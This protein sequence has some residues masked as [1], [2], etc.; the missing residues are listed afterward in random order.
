MKIDLHCHTISTKNGEDKT[1]N[2][3]VEKF[4][5][6]IIESDIKIVA[7]TNHNVFDFDQ[8][9]L[10]SESVKEYCSVWPGVEIDI[11][12]IK[13]NYHLIVI[14]NPKNANKFNDKISELTKGISPNKFT[15]KFEEVYYSVN[16]CD[17][18]YIPHFHKEP[19]IQ[20]E[21]IIELSNLIKDNS[22]LFRETSDYRSLGVFANFNYSVI[23]GSD[24]HRWDDYEKN[25]FA[26]LRLPIQSFEQFCLLA[27]KDELVINTLLNKKKCKRIYVSPHKSVKFSLPIYEDVNILFGQKGTG[28]SEI[29]KSLKSYYDKMSINNVIYVGSEKDS[30]FDNLL[31]TKDLKNDPC[32][33]GIKKF[34]DEFSKLNEWNDSLPISLSSYIEWISTRDNNKNKKKMKITNSVK[35]DTLKYDKKISSDYKTIEKLLN[36]KLDKIQLSNYLSSSE[37]NSLEVL[38]NKLI[39]N[40]SN[41]RFK[42]WKKVNAV[43]LSNWSIDKIKNIADKCS[44]TVSRP[45]TTGFSDF[46]DNRLKLFEIVDEINNS[47]ST[48]IKTEDEYLGLLESK[49]D[50]YIRSK[51]RMLCK[52]SRTAEFNSKI[53][54]LKNFKIALDKLILSFRKKNVQDDLQIIQELYSDGLN[55]ISYFIGLSKET[56]L[57]D[58]VKYNPSG[59]EKGI[60][61]LQKVINTEADVY[62]L[63]EPELGM[64]NSYINA[65]ILPK[66]IGHAKNKKTVIVA[67]H[68]ANIAVRTLPYTSVYREHENGIYSTYVGN[69]FI[70]NL[71]NIND[72]NDLKNWT[73]ESG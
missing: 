65:A 55:D 33:L 19:K 68:N 16:C 10:F 6:K 72:E 14:A 50:I 57:S 43:K 44:N 58:G 69:P 3:D 8:Y 66:I 46:A 38:L 41:T 2:V 35:L 45:S 54:N 59:G 36:I 13:S 56:V 62:L 32:K 18:L 30:D 47:F 48:P 20:E 28:K 23:I 31:N 70:D 4:T 15:A 64:G 73:Y 52:E 27:K 39:E 9:N 29:I 24:N 63:D 60:L 49:G 61:V 17:V 25:K 21:D 37:I 22:R 1:R 42:D 11:K 71:K 5:E 67:T 26:D 12:G 53:S 7:L 51:Y 34:D 40:I